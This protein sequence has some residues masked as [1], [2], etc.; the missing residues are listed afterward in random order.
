MNKAKPLSHLHNFQNDMVRTSVQFKLELKMKIVFI[1][2]LFVLLFI[3]L[4]IFFDIIYKIY[5]TISINFYIQ[6]VFGSYKMFSEKYIFSRNANFRKRKTYLGYLAVSEIVFRKINS[7]VWFVQTFYGNHFT[8]N[9]FRCLVRSNIL[10][11]ML[12]GKS[13]PMFGSV[14]HFMK[15]EIQF[16]Q[17]IISGVWFVDHFTENM[18]CV[19]NSSTCII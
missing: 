16:L 6:S 10:R 2:S 12:Y 11:K 8:E 17:K 3:G 1:F 5:C 14:K 4:I 9:Q 7:D 13:I 19:T 18:K 15:N